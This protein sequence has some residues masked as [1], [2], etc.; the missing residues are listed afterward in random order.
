L[1]LVGIGVLVYQL[2]VYTFV[3]K[4]FGPIKP[5]C[6]AVVCEKYILVSFFFSTS[7]LKKGISKKV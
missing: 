7:L 3:A 4:Y 2:V 1:I 6:P 5:L